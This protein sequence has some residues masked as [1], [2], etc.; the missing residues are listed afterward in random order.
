MNKS[1]HFEPF[2]TIFRQRRYNE[3]ERRLSGGEDMARRATKDLTEGNIYKNYSC[4]KVFEK[5]V[6]DLL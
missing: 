5:V 4:L 1:K 2:L 3:G 6:D